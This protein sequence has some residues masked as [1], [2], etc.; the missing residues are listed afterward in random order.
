LLTIFIYCYKFDSEDKWLP[1]FFPLTQKNINQNKDTITDEIIKVIN[2][3]KSS[4]LEFM[5]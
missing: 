4:L 1:L 3:N 2:K 5:K